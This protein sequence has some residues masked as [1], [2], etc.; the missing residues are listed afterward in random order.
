MNLCRDRRHRI[1]IARRELLQV[2]FSGLAGIGLSNLLAPRSR[3]GADEARRAPRARRV[4]LILLSGGASHHDTLDVKP[5]APA[6]IRGEFQAIDTPIPGVQVCEHLPRLAQRIDRL[7]L[8]RSMSHREF[9]HLPATHQVLTGSL[10]PNA[11]GSDLDRVASRKDWP[12]YGAALE[13]LRPRHD[14]IPSGVA[15]PTYLVEGPLTWP[16]Q[17]A[18]CLGAQFDPWQIRQ[19][20]SAPNFR[21]DS[22][23]LP[24]GFTMDRVIAR[25]GLLEEINGRRRQLD[26]LADRGQF[27]EKQQI[28]LDMLL[29]GKVAEAFD[30]SREPDTLRDRYGRNLYGQSLL[31]A[32]RLLEAGVSIVQANMGIVQ[33]W[34]THDANFP[35]LKDNLLPRLDQ[36]VAALL[37]DLAAR[38]LL[39]ET[40]VVMTG[41]FGRTPR[42]SFLP[43][44][45]LPGR[46]HWAS[47][48]TA[49][50]AGAGVQGGQV[51]GRSDD[52]GAYPVTRSFSLE[53]LGATVYS[54][55]GVDPDAAIRDQFGRPLQLNRGQ[56]MTPLFTGADV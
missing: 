49:A 31:L 53:D 39:D 13:F 7:A 32:R 37:D 9:S 1:G 24:A 22:L 50:F 19:D 40:L 16:G 2:G 51:I 18:G 46:D 12:C 30:I 42:I 29:S 55:L 26:Q 45:R 10:A 27:S 6:E 17:D 38:G 36:G 11:N 54:V 52:I 23:S 21:E 28:A 3:V 14:G 35:K 34:D 41:E 44:A 5:Q 25:R 43:G 20:P 33:T 4:L 48:F 8:V 15:L 56:P 47:V